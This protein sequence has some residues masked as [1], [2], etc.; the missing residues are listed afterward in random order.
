MSEPS[1]P[2]TRGGCGVIIYAAGLAGKL[3]LLK[4]KVGVRFLGV[5]EDICRCAISLWERHAEDVPGE[6]LRARRWGAQATSSLAS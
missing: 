2:G 4:P 1:Q 6:S 3:V 5:F